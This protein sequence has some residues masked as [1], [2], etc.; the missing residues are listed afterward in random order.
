MFSRRKENKVDCTGD[1]VTFGHVR[2][3]KR[4]KLSVTAERQLKPTY[5][6]TTLGKWT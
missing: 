4:L 6:K 3:G 2:I 1:M 5:H